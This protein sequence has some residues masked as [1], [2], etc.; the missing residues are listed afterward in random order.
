MKMASLL[1]LQVFNSHSRLA[2]LNL[3]ITE[4]SVLSSAEHCR[5]FLIALKYSTYSTQKCSNYLPFH[6]DVI[7]FGY[8]IEFS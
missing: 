8:M 4:Y 3:V 1:V 2:S 5:D 7:R 6:C